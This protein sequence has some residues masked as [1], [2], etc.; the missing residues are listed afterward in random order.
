[1]VVGKT[2]F[3]QQPSQFTTDIVGVVL[4]DVLLHAIYKKPNELQ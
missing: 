2:H 3:D 4:H 1:M